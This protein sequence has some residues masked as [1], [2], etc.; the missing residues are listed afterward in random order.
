M[1]LIMLRCVRVTLVCSLASLLLGHR[2]DSAQ[3]GSW[4]LTVVTWHCE[5]VFVAW[6]NNFV[7]QIY[8]SGP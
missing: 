5:T 3:C 4:Y 8:H 7:V 6:S 1:I 2:V